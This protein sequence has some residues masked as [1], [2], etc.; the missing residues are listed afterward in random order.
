MLLWQLILSGWDRCDGRLP[1]VAKTWW[2]I[3]SGCYAIFSITRHCHWKIGRCN[4]KMSTVY[5]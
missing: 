4:G 3:S 1:D 2:R 5:F